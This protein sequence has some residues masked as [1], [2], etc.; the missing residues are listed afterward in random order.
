MTEEVA[1][2]EMTA[3]AVT[4][5]AVAE[6][7]AVVEEEGINLKMGQFENLKMIFKS[8]SNDFQIFKF[9]NFQIEINVTA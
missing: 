8:P 2:E 7:T 5:E 9:S 4:G 3:E 6:I 1:T